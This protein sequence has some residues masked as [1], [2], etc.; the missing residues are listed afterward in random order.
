[1]QGSLTATLFDRARLERAA[2]LLAVA[3]VVSMPWST[4]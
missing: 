3:V 4:T 1:M 2:D